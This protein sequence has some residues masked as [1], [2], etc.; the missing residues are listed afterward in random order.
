LAAP[1]DD[2][3][4]SRSGRGSKQKKENGPPKRRRWAIRA[5]YWAGVAAAW[6]L[7]ALFVFGL[8]M[9]KDLPNVSELQAPDAEPSVVVLARD[10]STVATYGDVH[11]E[12]LTFEEFPAPLLAAVVATEDRR[13][14]QHVGFDIWG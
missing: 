11:G 14:F 3:M 10:G 5:L 8:Y 13:F 6:A 12:L 9:A 4:A 2:I 1:R 7:V